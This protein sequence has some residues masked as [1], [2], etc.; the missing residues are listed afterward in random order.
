VRVLG[1]GGSGADFLCRGPVTASVIDSF[2][3]P[4]YGQRIPAPRLVFTA[5][6]RLPLR[7]TTV[8]VPCVES[9]DS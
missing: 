3:S 9:Q 6:T 2:V 1:I 4:D 8:I 5:R 7:L